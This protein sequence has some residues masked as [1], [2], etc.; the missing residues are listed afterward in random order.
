[1]IA[2]STLRPLSGPRTHGSAARVSPSHRESPKVREARLRRRAGAAYTRIQAEGVALARSLG[3]HHTTLTHRKA[4]QGGLANVL[5]EIDAWE[6][7]GHDT[8]PLLEAMIETRLDARRRRGEERPA[9]VALV[10]EE[11]TLDC[12]EDMAGARFHATGDPRPWKDA[13]LRYVAYAH[14][15]LLPSL[16]A[17]EQAGPR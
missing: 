5:V 3:V 11:Q 2:L 10:V 8:L 16:V 6:A 14:A 15:T 4:G 7:E 17:H 1:M 13:V 9:P 12:A